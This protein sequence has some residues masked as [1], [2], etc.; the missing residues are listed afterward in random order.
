MILPDPDE[1]MP[2]PKLLAGH[3]FEIARGGHTIRITPTSQRGFHSGRRL[4][5]IECLTCEFLLHPA[6]TGPLEHVDRHLRHPEDGWPLPDPAPLDPDPAAP[7]PAPMR[8]ILTADEVRARTAMSDEA[9]EAMLGVEPMDLHA[10]PPDSI[11]PY[12]R[13]PGVLSDAAYAEWL[14]QVSSGTSID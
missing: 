5:R 3:A 7:A 13:D 10:D 11:R 2:M 1:V 6:T 12:L 14:S 9:L 8:P 4:H